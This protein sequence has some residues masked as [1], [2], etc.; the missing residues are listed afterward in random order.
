MEVTEYRICLEELCQ[1]LD[2]GEIT[3]QPVRIS[4][5]LLHRMYSV[6]TNNG[7]FAVKA[8]NPQIMVRPEAKQN[9]ID[10]ELIAQCVEQGIP[11]V[12]ARVFNGVQ[13][14]ELN[15]QYYLIYEWVDGLSLFDDDIQVIHCSKIGETLARIHNYDYS[16]LTISSKVESVKESLTDWKKYLEHGKVNDLEWCDALRQHQDKLY[17]WE[18]ISLNAKSELNCD[19]VISHR[20][21]DPKNVLWQEENPI[22][23]DWESAG[24][25]NPLYE[26]LEVAVYWSQNENGSVSKD[27][28]MAVVEAYNNKSENNLSYYKKA[29]EAGY[30]NQLRWLEYSLKRS[31]GLETCDDQ[32]KQLGAEQVISTLV[33]LDDYAKMLPTLLIWLQE[34]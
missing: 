32:D 6:T 2:L 15:Q 13:L 20:D 24:T 22:L 26:L 31:L 4:G 25:I 17:Q 10:S 29:L 34:L 21:L 12:A 19:L 3:V 8:L 16:T 33:G 18:Q 28:F 27:K 11:A 5:G 14:Q 9:F 7:K 23:I 1:H 30:F